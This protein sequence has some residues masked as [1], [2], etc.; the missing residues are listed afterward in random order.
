MRFYTK[1]V[2]VTATVLVLLNDDWAPSQFALPL[3]VAIAPP[4]ALPIAASCCPPP[5]RAGG[6]RSR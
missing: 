1:M 3:E 6:E 4:G 2:F 5:A